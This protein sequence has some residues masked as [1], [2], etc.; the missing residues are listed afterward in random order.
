[1]VVRVIRARE[2][3]RER[4]HRFPLV[5]NGNLIHIFSGLKSNFNQKTIRLTTW[6]WL[7]FIVPLNNTGF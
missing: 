5:L 7:H 4:V 2:R 6:F 3:E 1:M